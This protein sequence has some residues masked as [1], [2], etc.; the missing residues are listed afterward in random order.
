MPQDADILN[1][2][3][4]LYWHSSP[5]RVPSQMHSNPPRVLMQIFGLSHVG[6]D[7]LPHSSIS[8]RGI[9]HKIALMFLEMLTSYHTLWFNFPVII[10]YTERATFIFL[11]TFHIPSVFKN[12][13]FF[14][15]T[16]PDK[17]KT[18]I[19]L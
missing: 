6:G 19:S 9:P 3:N 1:N 4:L 14:V 18:E 17:F 2:F 7:A 15:D 5:Y 10:S 13:G 11:L 12:P 16:T 8:E